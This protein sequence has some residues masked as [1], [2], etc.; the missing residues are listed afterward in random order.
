MTTPSSNDYNVTKLM[1]IYVS[2]HPVENTNRQSMKLRVSDHPVKST[3][4]VTTIPTLSKSTL[5]TI[6]STLY[7]RKVQENDVINVNVYKVLEKSDVAIED[8]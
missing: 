5:P 3:N 7:N 1:P 2:D 4:Q 8:E 6:V